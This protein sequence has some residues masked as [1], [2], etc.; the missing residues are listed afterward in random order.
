[1][2]M[3]SSC[4]AVLVAAPASGQGKTLVTAAFVR[5]QR[6]LGRRVRVFKTGP[7]FLDPMVLEVASASP[8][9]NLDLRLVGAE[10][11]ARRLADAAARADLIVVEGV[12]GL[13]DGSPC[14]AE[15]AAAFGLSVMLVI[16]AAA[17]AQTFGAIALGLASYRGDIVLHGALA[18]RVAGAGH[19]AMLR[20]ALPA[21]LRWIGHLPECAEA[22]LP[23]RHL[24]LVQA[25]EIDDLERRID[26]AADAL[27]VDDTLPEPTRFDAPQAQPTELLLQGRRI[28]VARDEAF[29]FIYPANIDLLRELGAELVFFSPL[30]DP[31]LPRCDALWLPG[32]YPELHLGELTANRAM[33]DAIVAHQAAERPILAECGGMLY[34][35]ESLCDAAGNS[36]A[37]VGLLPAA[38]ALGPRL[39]ALGQQGVALPAGELRGH[40]FHHSTLDTALQPWRRA[41]TPGGVPGEAVYRVGALTAS[42]VH[43]YFPSNPQAAAG[44][45]R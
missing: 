7:D 4:P 34:L 38:A 45:F 17:M 31:E 20:D 11:C 15:L 42:Y 10:G 25:V 9:D 12:M 3:I 33:R 8:V 40:T 24:G 22:A 41:A 13:H 35:C 37:M 21:G 28:A 44:L 16:D 18:N 1:M 32:G 14:S 36:A 23:E 6:R 2:R 43:F 29:S 39:A 27:C 30:R 26:A 19:A 5:R